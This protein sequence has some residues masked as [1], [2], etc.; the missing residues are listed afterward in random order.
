MQLNSQDG[1]TL[2]ELLIAALLLAFG[3]MAAI[4]VETACIHGTSF[5]SHLDEATALAHARL[6]KLRAVADPTTLT[7]QTTTN[8]KSDGTTGGTDDIYTSTYKAI[9]GPTPNSR[10]VTV[11][12]SWNG[13]FGTQQVSVQG[14]ATGGAP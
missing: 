7:T 14:L 8:L 10:W 12:V 3:V 11:T 5:A 6:V 1:F 9:Q 2:V 13:A 4:A